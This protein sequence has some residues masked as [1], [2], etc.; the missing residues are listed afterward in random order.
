M[1]DL[2]KLLGKGLLYIILLP[3]GIVFFAGYG[4]YLFVVWIIMF[5]RTIILFFKGKPTGLTLPEDIKALS[6]LNDARDFSQQPAQ[7]GNGITFNLNINGQ[8]VGQKTGTIVHSK[9][10]D[11]I[12]YSNKGIENKEEDNK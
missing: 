2:L 8:N 6:I 1:L 10:P 7:P 11:V 5:F 12:D 3:L 4:V 9:N